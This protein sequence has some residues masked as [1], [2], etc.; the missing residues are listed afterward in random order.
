MNILK[1][2]IVVFLVFSFLVMLGFIIHKDYGIGIDEPINRKNGV[3]SLNY[4][5]TKFDIKNNAGSLKNDPALEKYKET[6]QNY[7]DQDYGVVLDLPLIILERVFEINDTARQYEMRHLIN[8]LIF[9]LGAFAL[10]QI[11]SVRFNSWKVGL[12]SVLLLVTSPRIFAESFYNNK[13]ILFMSLFIISA[14]TMLR[15]IKKPSIV[16]II[17]HGVMCS[18]VINVRI[19]GIILPLLMIP[20][21]ILLKLQNRINYIKIFQLISIYTIVTVIVTI[22]LWPWLWSN[23]IDNFKQ[24]ILNMSQFRWIGWVQF[25]GYYYPSNNLPWKYVPYWIMISTPILYSLLFAIGLINIIRNLMQSGRKF[26]VNNKNIDD[27]IF[28]ILLFSMPVATIVLNSV[29]YNGWRHL[30]FIYPFFILIATNGLVFILRYIKRNFITKSILYLIIII[31]I[32]FTIIWM[33]R[34]HPF[35]NVYFNKIAGQNWI[36][37]FETDYWGLS[38]TTALRHILKNDNREQIK[39]KSIQF[40]PLE[41]AKLMLTNNDK[42]RLIVVHDINEANYILTHHQFMSNKESELWQE[43]LK[44][45]KKFHDIKVQNEII[46]SIYKNN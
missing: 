9:I 3:I 37:K 28:M 42:K 25:N 10:Y 31:N 33:S 12:F 27:I 39:I 45:L 32:I 11:S 46:F 8:Y 43:K 41:Y 34:A 1:Q 4:L 19:A 6:L 29:L 23:P 38:T 15:T 20:T 13:D 18:I 30:Y 44:K 14:F 22:L 40:L 5:L 21:F 2:K 36:N 17:L 24:A 7:K 16:N 35:Q 26:Y